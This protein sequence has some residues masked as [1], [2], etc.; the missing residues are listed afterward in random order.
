MRDDDAV[1]GD[2]ATVKGHWQPAPEDVPLKS[3]IDQHRGGENAIPSPLIY[4]SMG[5]QQGELE[6]SY[7]PVLG[8]WAKL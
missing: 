8:K 1:L 7:E 2:I 5:T 6:G 4:A 3:F